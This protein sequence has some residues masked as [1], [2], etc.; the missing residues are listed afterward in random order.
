MKLLVLLTNLKPPRE[1]GAILGADES[2]IRLR[3][4]SI[5]KQPYRKIARKNPTIFAQVKA[6]IDEGLTN[7]QI[8]DKLGICATSIRKYTYELGLKTN[9]VK[10]KP[11]TKETLTLTDIQWEVLYGSLLGDM[12]IALTKRIDMIAAQKSGTIGIQ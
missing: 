10:A 9:S 8:A 2:I 3:L 4:K 12:S 6:L 5:G 1:I 11:I 7:Q